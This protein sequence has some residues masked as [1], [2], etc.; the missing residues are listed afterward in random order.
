MGWEAKLYKSKPNFHKHFLYPFS[1][2][3]FSFSF[4][5]NNPFHTTDSKIMKRRYSDEE[6]TN[7]CVVRRITNS[8]YFQKEAEESGE[9]KK[10]SRKKTRLALQPKIADLKSVSKFP[11]SHIV[12]HYQALIFSQLDVQTWWSGQM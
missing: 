3:T 11:P 2:D 1:P 10:L 9:A 12:E 8:H 6:R 4:P 7:D 5:S